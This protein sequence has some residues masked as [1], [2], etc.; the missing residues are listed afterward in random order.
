MG[1]SGRSFKR[2][3]CIAVFATTSLVLMTY[4]GGRGSDELKENGIEMKFNMLGDDFIGYCTG[5]KGSLHGNSDINVAAMFEWF[6]L[7]SI[8]LT[9]FVRLVAELSH[10]DPQAS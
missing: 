8:T 9:C 5:Q 6:L 4:Y 10:W 7:A 3:L 2:V 1:G